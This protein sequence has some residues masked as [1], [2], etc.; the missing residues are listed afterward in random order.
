MDESVVDL[1]VYIVVF[2]LIFSINKARVAK[3]D[4]S[5][6]AFG[7]LFGL[8]ARMLSGL[9]NLV[10]G[11]DYLE[12]NIQFHYSTFFLVILV[13][14]LVEEFFFRDFLLRRWIQRSDSKIIVLVGVMIVSLVFAGI[15]VQYGASIMM[16]SFFSS[17][18][19][20]LAYLKFGLT[21]SIFAHVSDNLVGQ[22]LL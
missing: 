6:A 14:P 12:N 17:I 21:G 22:L 8:C 1:C 19:Y 18:V 5:G 3:I 9:I 2:I 11:S 20:S 4:F 15:H 13:A 16:K 7:V 10:V